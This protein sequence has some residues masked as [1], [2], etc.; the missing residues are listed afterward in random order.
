MAEL[1]GRR[2][3]VVRDDEPVAGRRPRAD[4]QR[5]QAA[6]SVGEVADRGRPDGRR[7][8]GVDVAAESR[9]PADPPARACAGP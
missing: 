5:R 9:D 2:T 3:E 8:R 7:R 6:G 1:S 4:A